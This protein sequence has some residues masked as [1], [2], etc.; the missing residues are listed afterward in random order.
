[1][2]TCVRQVAWLALV[3]ALLSSCLPSEATGPAASPVVTETPTLVPAP[4][5]TRTPSPPGSLID[6]A[7]QSGDT[8]P[9]V[10]AHFNTTVEE[11]FAANPEL[12]PAATTL[13]P[14]FIVHI[15]AYYVPL[16]GLPFT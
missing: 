4:P 10:A 12:P 7:A 9:A 8:L 16:T 6:Y 14:G 3:T 11:I 2:M 13:P 5:P 1:M 15:S